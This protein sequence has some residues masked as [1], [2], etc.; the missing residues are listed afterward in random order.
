MIDLIAIEAER[1]AA[2]IVGIVE[3]ENGRLDVHARIEIER[4]AADAIRWGRG[5]P[6]DDDEE[7]WHG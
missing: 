2:E 7:D 1:L 5:I 4:A 6:D 3:R